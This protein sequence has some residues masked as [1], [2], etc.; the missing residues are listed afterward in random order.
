MSEGKFSRFNPDCLSREEYKDWLLPEES[1]NTK[2]RGKKKEV[3][4]EK[5]EVQF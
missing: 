4:T 2:A 3:S 1:D 5:G